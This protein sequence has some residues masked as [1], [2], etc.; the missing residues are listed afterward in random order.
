MAALPEKFDAFVAEMSGDT[1][2]REV[3][4]VSYA[5]LGAGDV[6]IR[7][8]WSGV[9]YKDA[10]A[11]IPGGKVARLSPLIP[12]IDLAGIVID[13]GS[14]DIGVGDQVV[15]HGYGLGVAHHGGFST[16]ARVPRDWVVP[17]PSGLSCREAMSLGT[18]GFTAALSV[19]KLE[20]RGL[21]PG[22]GPVLVTGASGGVGSI[23]VGILAAR[24]YEVVASTGKATATDW[25]RDLGAA[26]VVERIGRAESGR[27]LEPEQ[28]AAAVD[29]V[30]GET[31][32][33]VLKS[34][35]YGAA[36][37][38]SGNTGG[39]A[40][41]TTVFPFIL[42]GTALLGVDSVSCPATLRRDIWRSLAQDYRPLGLEQIVTDE[43]PLQE[44]PAA[45]DRVHAGG[46]VGRTLV[47]LD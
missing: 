11:T 20:E 23:A 3:R 6:T 25:L 1:V 37:A 16:A 44:L 19:R 36:V 24:G 4:R 43:V 46:C 32:G 35:R 22:Q 41:A 17:L 14:R 31:L 42:R 13:S 10:L 21:R 30:G 38:A 27:A 5:D 45:L 9:N 8:A 33:A 28:W 12:G 18:A 26:D 39:P 47:R 29:C 40:L 2:V 15:V 34:L 7:V